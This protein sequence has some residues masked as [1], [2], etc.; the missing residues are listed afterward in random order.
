[1]IQPHP[2][3]DLAPALEPEPEPAKAPQLPRIEIEGHLNLKGIAEFRGVRV[4]PDR[5]PTSELRAFGMDLVFDTP[6]QAEQFAAA[7][8]VMAAQLQIAW[9]RNGYAE[10][11]PPAP[12]ADPL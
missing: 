6:A 8:Q 1:M 7:A 4:H 9:E 12:Q 2:Y 3:D 10:K 5:A 11:R